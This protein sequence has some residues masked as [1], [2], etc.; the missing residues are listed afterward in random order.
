MAPYNNYSLAA[1]TPDSEE[2][3]DVQDNEE[4]IVPESAV[5]S[6]P[7]L[8]KEVDMENDGGTYGVIVMVYHVQ[9]VKRQED[10]S[11]HRAVPDDTGAW[12]GCRAGALVSA[13]GRRS[14]RPRKTQTE[15]MVAKWFKV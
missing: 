15:I 2:E 4:K 8:G 11:F 9:E 12:A 1:S 10:G 5:A 7:T 14:E 6:A 3:L 13:R